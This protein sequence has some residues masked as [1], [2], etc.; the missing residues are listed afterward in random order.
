MPSRLHP[1]PGRLTADERERLIHDAA[2]AGL[3]L[4]AYVRSK[5]GL[6]SLKRGGPHNPKGRPRKEPATFRDDP[7]G[8]LEVLDEII[9]RD[10]NG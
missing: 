7:R 9:D 5:L 1:M 4:G 2:A 6:A 3:P 8:F 10:R